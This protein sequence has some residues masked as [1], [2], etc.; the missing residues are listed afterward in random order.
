MFK[1][2]VANLDYAT[3]LE[4]LQAIVGEYCTDCIVELPRDRKTGATKGFAFV[5]AQTQESQEHLMEK[6]NSCTIKGRTPSTKKFS[7]SPRARVP[8][9]D[10]EYNER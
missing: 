5:I 8:R 9:R 7:D 6:L 3:T 2:F 4:E 1:L 10:E